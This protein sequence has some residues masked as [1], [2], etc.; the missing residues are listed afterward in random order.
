[1]TRELDY[2]YEN[3]FGA[4][5]NYADLGDTSTTADDVKYT[6]SQYQDTTNYI[7]KPGTIIAKDMN[8]TVLATRAPGLLRRTGKIASLTDVITG[9]RNPADGT[10]Y[11]GSNA[12][13]Q[14]HYDEFG[15]LMDYTDPVGY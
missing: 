12:T 10:P 8:G 4:M 2:D 11:T 1:M 14:F 7:I 15:N 9:G 13:W 5:T 3:T 6:I